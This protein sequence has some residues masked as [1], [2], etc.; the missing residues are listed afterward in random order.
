[1][2]KYEYMANP[3]NINAVKIHVCH[4]N[5]H[6]MLTN[7]WRAPEN[8]SAKK[9]EINE[10]KKLN[11]RWLWNLYIINK[12]FDTL[13]FHPL[14]QII[15]AMFVLFRSNSFIDFVRKQKHSNKLKFILQKQKFMQYCLFFIYVPQKENYTG[16]EILIDP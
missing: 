14:V 7:L 12:H 8:K 2:F 3:L 10:I 4:I 13:F 1:M 16:N 5:I 9:P 15:R 6:N 11:K